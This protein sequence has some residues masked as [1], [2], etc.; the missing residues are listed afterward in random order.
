MDPNLLRALALAC[1]CA[2]A[3]TAASADETIDAAA[4]GFEASGFEASVAA[5]IVGRVVGAR[6]GAPLPFAAVA[7]GNLDLVTDELGRFQAEGLTAGDVELVVRVDGHRQQRLRLTLEPGE[8]VELEVA[9]RRLRRPRNETVVHSTP[10]WRV[11]RRRLLPEAGTAGRHALTRADVEDAAGGFGDPLRAVLKIP[12]VSGDE[13]SRAW[14]QVRGGLPDEVQVEID[15]IAVRHP[16]H[17]DGVI[18]VFSRDL[19]DGLDL[20]VAGTPLDRPGGLS[21]GLYASYIDAPHDRADGTVDLSL[22]AGSAHLA[23]RADEEGEHAFVVGVRRSFLGPYLQAAQV[24]GAFESDRAEGAYETAPPQV[25]FGEYLVRY[26]HRPTAGQQLRVTLLATHDR[27]LWDDANMRQRMVGGSLDWGWL[28]R[29]DVAVRVQAAHAS[30][31]QDEPDVDF[32]L[33]HPRRY[34]DA[35]HRTHL[36]ASTHLGSETRRLTV[37]GAVA[38]R[39]RR[40][41]GDFDDERTVPAWAWLPQADLAVPRLTLNSTVT[42]P[43]AAL[44]V[45][46]RA[47]DLAGPLGARLGLRLDLLNP[48]AVV[49]AGPRLELRLSLPS[50]TTVTASGS[51]VSQARTDALVVDRDVG[52]RD[53]VPERATTAQLS[54]E[55][56]VGGALFVGVTGWYRYYDRLVVFTSDDPAA[57]G[58]WSNDGRGRAVGLEARGVWR[59]GRFGAEASY[60][61]SSSRRTTPYGAT[62]PVTTAAG[63]DPRHA[64]RLAIDA[65]IGPRK[66]GRLGVDYSWRS[67]WAIGSLE[68][69]PQTDEGTFRWAI[70]A[71]DDRRR[72]DLHRIAARFEQI[73]ELRL[74]RLVGTIEV[75]ATPGSAGT[76][77]DC[78]SVLDSEGAPPECRTLD[79]LPVVMPW[80]GLRAE[81]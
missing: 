8:Q 29:P 59:R 31:W 27:M 72:P 4:S 48:S 76:V 52:D 77:E 21:G 32:Y 61:L 51:M 56:E 43:E 2:V 66:G 40:V 38:A 37:G 13:G 28:P 80:L 18:S 67:G 63:G 24:A 58:S 69:V 75:A 68:R 65:L 79:F 6:S 10:P 50:G 35:D 39:T 49:R 14:F 5:T 1:V 41:E 47:D 25:D 53:L 11:V 70:T 23:V 55:Q 22:L 45:H 34:L 17:M 36:R 30:S 74:L 33:P 26:S 42:W 9:L 73:H 62:G 19:L 81:F 46:A 44:W 71:L 78:P 54:V 64:L 57:P 16:T 7:V 12:G 20:H 3:P 60:S 15:G